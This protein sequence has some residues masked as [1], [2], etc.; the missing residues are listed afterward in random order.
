MLT[1]E[2]ILELIDKLVETPLSEISLSQGEFSVSLKKGSL[3]SAEANIN[4]SL[5]GVNYTLQDIPQ[6]QSQGVQPAT[7][8][9]PQ[10]NLTEILSPMVGTFYSAPSPDSAVFAE[11]GQQIKTGDVLCIIEAMKMMNE[12][13]SEINGIVAEVCVQNAQTIEY[14]QVLFRIKAN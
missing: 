9:E 3:Q 12:F 10:S 6:M 5:T 4:T 13:P 8:P 1:Y 14:G 2:Q 11:V 7:A